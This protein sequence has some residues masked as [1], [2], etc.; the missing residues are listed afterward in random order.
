MV[1]GDSLCCDSLERGFSFIGSGVVEQ[2]SGESKRK[3]WELKSK[4]NR[5]GIQ[6]PLRKGLGNVQS[7]L[8]ASLRLGHT[9]TL[10][11]V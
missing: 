3:V 4:M 8:T 1:G 7:F 11:R 10:R 5:L 2:A 6:G 9:G